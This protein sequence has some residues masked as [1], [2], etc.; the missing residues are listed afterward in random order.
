MSQYRPRN[1]R[2]MERFSA[3]ILVRV[4]H[5]GER[6]AEYRTH[7][8]SQGGMGLKPGRVMFWRGTRL[9]LQLYAPTRNRLISQR[10]PAVVRYCS[11]RGMG[12]KFR[13]GE[14]PAL[15][16]EGLGLGEAERR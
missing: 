9:E 1:R 2:R 8:V 14:L 10:I 16:G 4:Y 5:R 15:R 7:D 11:G 3:D 6:I 13:S 12:L